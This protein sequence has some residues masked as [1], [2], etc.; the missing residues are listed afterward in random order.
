[1]EKERK[2]TKR[3]KMSKMPFSV[4]FGILVAVL[5]MIVVAAGVLMAPGFKV[6]EVYCEGN[7]L[8]QSEE[9]FA[10]AQISGG[11]NIFLIGLGKAE[12]NVEK[13]PMIKEANIK[14]VFPDK[15]CIAV[16]ER[17]PVAYIK[18]GTECIAI[19]NESII[20]KRFESD[21]AAKLIKKLTPDFDKLKEEKTDESEEEKAP[22]EEAETVPEEQTDAEEYFSIPLIEGIE[23]KNADENKKAKCSDEGKFEDVIKIC[24]GLNNAGLLNKATYLNVTDMQNINLV[25]ENRLD[26]RLGTMENIEYRAKF[27]AEVINTKISAYE[28]LILDY[29]RDDIYARTFE[30][31]KKDIKTLEESAEESAEEDKEKTDGETAEEEV[32]EKTEEPAEEEKL[33][34]EASMKMD[35]EQEE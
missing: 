14:R 11:K 9:I 8:V 30:E 1:M 32:E 31:E 28:S 27:L 5:V 16:T 7:S 22:E 33:Q 35:G 3:N 26:V 25:I 19:D 4:R 12:R 23:A 10:N 29:T 34:A 18:A 2:K 17:V 21:Q 20:I 6:T 24:N 13:L 15:I